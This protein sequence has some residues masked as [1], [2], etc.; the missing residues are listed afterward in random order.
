MSCTQSKVL[1]NIVPDAPFCPQ[2]EIR[3]DGPCGSQPGCT[4]VYGNGELGLECLVGYIASEWHIL[5]AR[6]PTGTCE[7]DSVADHGHEAALVLCKRHRHASADLRD[8][9]IRGAAQRATQG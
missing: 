9:A 2:S 1:E 6:S 3:A 7:S 4:G 5:S 8:A